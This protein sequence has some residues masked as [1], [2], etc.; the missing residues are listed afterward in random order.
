MTMEPGI[1]VMHMMKT[2]SRRSSA[3]AMGLQSIVAG[4]CLLVLE[5][6]RRASCV[7]EADVAF[8]V[9]ARGAG[10]GADSLVMCAVSLLVLT[11]LPAAS[12]VCSSR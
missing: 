1:T 9:A 6:P 7:A 12:E 3:A 11:W 2:L 4:P 5:L 10:A 8:S